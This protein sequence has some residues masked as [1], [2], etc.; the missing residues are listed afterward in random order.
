MEAPK[1]F[2]NLFSSVQQSLIGKVTP[3]LRAVRLVFK[4]DTAYKLIFYYD[5]PLSED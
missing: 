3:N 2:L 5:Q 4:N 1:G